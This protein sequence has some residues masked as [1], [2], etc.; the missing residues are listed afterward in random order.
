M[1][2]RLLYASRAVAPIDDK[3]IES[4]LQS[5]RK[6]NPQHG[7]SGVLCSHNVGNVFLQVLEGGRSAVNQLYGN[8]VRDRRHQDVT[9]LHFDEVRERRFSG[10]RMGSVD[11]NRVNLSTIL[12]YSEKPTFD[13]F[14]MTGDAA[15][16]LLQE[17]ID[18]AAVT[19]RVDG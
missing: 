3:L 9:L 4:I 1:L 19:S 17:L 13:P 12:R 15:M 18:T 2:V 16:A 6:N 5:S 8:I 14:T 10:W 11:L 7:V